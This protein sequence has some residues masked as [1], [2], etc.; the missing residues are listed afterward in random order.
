MT[1]ANH[2]K[3][4]TDGLRRSLKERGND[5]GGKSSIALKPQMVNRLPGGS[6]LPLLIARDERT[7]A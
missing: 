7:W 6:K 1:I 5:L 3:K 4:E 2:V